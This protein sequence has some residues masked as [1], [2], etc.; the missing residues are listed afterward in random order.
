[1]AAQLADRI[2]ARW[3]L[4]FSP[5][6]APTYRA[7]CSC[8]TLVAFDR[9]DEVF[10]ATEALMEELSEGGQ[11]VEALVRSEHLEGHR[12]PADEGWYA[13]IAEFLEAFG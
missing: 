7:Q 3:A 4:L 12:L 8:P 11:R 2:G 1:M 5:I 13:S 6:Y 9:A 10:A